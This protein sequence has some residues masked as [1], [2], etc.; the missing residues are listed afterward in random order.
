MSQ[1]MES[2]FRSILSKIGKAWGWLLAFGMISVLAGLAVIFWPGSALAAIAILFGLYLVLGGIFR[3]VSAFAIPEESTWL[4]ALQA[5]LAVISIVVG[6]VLLRNL[7]LSLLVLV[8]TLGLYFIII[9]VTELFIAFGHRELPNRGWVVASGILNVVAG[10][11]VFFYPGISLLALTIVLGIWLIIYG[12]ILVVSAFRV[13]SA[14]GAI[15]GQAQ[16]LSPT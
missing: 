16:R 3:F 10:A 7:G 14:A 2:D 4:R 13:R 1:V 12:V 9:G 8:L 5:I 15:G 6:L 11:I